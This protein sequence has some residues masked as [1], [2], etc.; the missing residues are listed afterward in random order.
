MRSARDILDAP[1]WR[2]VARVV[3]SA[4]VVDEMAD[5][6]DHGCIVGAQRKGWELELDIASSERIEMG[7]QACAQKVVARHAA[8]AYD[9]GDAVAE[10]WPFEC[11]AREFAAPSVL[12]RAGRTEDHT[13]LILELSTCCRL[14]RVCDGRLARVVEGSLVGFDVALHCCFES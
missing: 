12:D 4:L 14:E 6:G 10:T 3:G 8:T 13:E 9:R 2:G 7:A 1:L 11:Y 5:P